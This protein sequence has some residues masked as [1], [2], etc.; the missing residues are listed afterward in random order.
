MGFQ[1]E[2][3]SLEL[4]YKGQSYAFRAPS[5]LENKALVANLR[6]MKA[7]DDSIDPIDEYVNFLVSLGIPKEILEKMSVKGILSLF[8]YSVG[9]KKN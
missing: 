2:D 6:A 3:E 1:Y 8:E 7:G 4:N 5:H 9:A